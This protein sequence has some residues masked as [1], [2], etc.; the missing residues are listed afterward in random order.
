MKSF[1]HRHLDVGSKG[2]M[3]AA[4]SCCDVSAVSHSVKPEP[5][6]SLRF[7]SSGAASFALFAIGAF[8]IGALAVGVL[9]IGRLFLG[10]LSIGSA[11]FGCLEIDKLKVKSC[12]CSAH[13]NPEGS[14]G[15]CCMK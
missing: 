13:S 3:S 1:L 2:R 11:R 5:L 12:E 8:S 15:S 6:K 7:T 14:E 4:F 10:K 9:A